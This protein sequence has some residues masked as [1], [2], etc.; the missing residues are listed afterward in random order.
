MEST[1]LSPTQ[2]ERQPL[3]PSEERSVSAAVPDEG[4]TTTSE[5]ATVASADDA[6]SLARLF[7][8]LLVDSIPGE[9]S[10]VSQSTAE[11]NLKA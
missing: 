11:H 8:S 9:Q 5:S 1:N 6:R 3:L 7:A 10:D 2:D 4:T